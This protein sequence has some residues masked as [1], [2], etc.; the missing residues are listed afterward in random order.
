[1]PFICFAEKASIEVSVFPV[2]ICICPVT[3]PLVRHAQ[4]AGS[5][6]MVHAMPST[7][8]LHCASIVAQG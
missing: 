8:Q 3:P 7:G 4:H 2:S 5:G 1:V 6:C